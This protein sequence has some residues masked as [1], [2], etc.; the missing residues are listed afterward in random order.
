MKIHRN[1]SCNLLKKFIIKKFMV[2]SFYFLSV[3][4]NFTQRTI[5]NDPP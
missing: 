3:R 5:H 2:S 4:E 1:I